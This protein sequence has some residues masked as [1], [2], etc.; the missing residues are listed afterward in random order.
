[1]RIKAN[2]SPGITAM[3]FGRNDRLVLSL[4]WYLSNVAFVK[5]KNT[6]NVR[7][8]INSAAGCYKVK[9]FGPT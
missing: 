5:F 7:F 4:E 9:N 3:D 2:I 8:V 1:M 6:Y